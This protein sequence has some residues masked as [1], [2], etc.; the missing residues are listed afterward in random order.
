[1]NLSARMSCN[2][3]ILVCAKSMKKVD[4]TAS[5]ERLKCMVISSLSIAEVHDLALS[6]NFSSSDGAN[7]DWMSMTRHLPTTED[8]VLRSLL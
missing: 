4:G 7:E 8:V 3:T 1:M 5:A 2:L 6:L